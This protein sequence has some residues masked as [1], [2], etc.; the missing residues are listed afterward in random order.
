[1]KRSAAE[2]LYLRLMDLGCRKKSSGDVLRKIGIIPRSYEYFYTLLEGH[3]IL[4]ALIPKVA[5]ILGPQERGKRVG[6]FFS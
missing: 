5:P 6:G 3:P 4:T 2:S 1:M